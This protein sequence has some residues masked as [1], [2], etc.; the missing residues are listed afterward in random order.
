MCVD[1]LSMSPVNLA[2]VKLAIRSVSFSKMRRV[3][4]EVLQ[5]ETANEIK[6]YL[7]GCLPEESLKYLHSIRALG[8]SN[9][10]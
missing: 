5:M 6:R 10:D 9:N 4:Q 1:E 8:N 2:E 7:T 3:A